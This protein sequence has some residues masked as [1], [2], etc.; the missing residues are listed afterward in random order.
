MSKSQRRGLGPI[1]LLA[2][3]IIVSTVVAWLLPHSAWLALVGPVIM[4][5]TLVGASALFPRPSGVR[6]RA[7]RQALFLGAALLLAGVIVIRQDPALLASLLPIFG[8]GAAAI[9]ATSA[10]KDAT[11]G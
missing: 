2:A 3:G 11:S 9:V 8:G 1:L 7:I 4:A 5:A 10:L 6:R